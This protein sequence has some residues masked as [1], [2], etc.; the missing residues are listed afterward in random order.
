MCEYTSEPGISPIVS[1]KRKYESLQAESADEHDLLGFFRT[2][3]EEDAIKALACLRSSDDI[4]STLHQARNSVKAQEESPGQEPP[5]IPSHRSTDQTIS[6]YDLHATSGSMDAPSIYPELN[7][8]DGR[9][10]WVLPIEPYVCWCIPLAASCQRMVVQST[11]AQE[12]DTNNKHVVR[13]PTPMGRIPRSAR[14]SGGL[15]APPN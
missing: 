15:P 8:S 3:S 2:A 7:D 1:L 11:L 13:N 4:Q 14:Q 10:P 6:P 9:T 12:R 5:E